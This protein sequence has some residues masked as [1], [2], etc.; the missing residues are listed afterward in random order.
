[1]TTGAP[2]APGTPPGRGAVVSS[3]AG[4][5]AFALTALPAA[6]G[7]EA[8]GY[9]SVVVA[10][11]LFAVSLPVSLYSLARAAVRTARGERVTVPGLFFLRGSAP[12]TVRRMLL[13]SLLA[14]LAV[15]VATASAEPFG[16]LVPV[17]PLALAG[18]WGARHG[19]FPPINEPAP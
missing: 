4:T 19:R 1:M 16:I 8:T 2:R 9:A 17:Y 6:A 5:A 18:L 14:C 13:G 12:P 7:L 11:V 3:W 10:V 15:T